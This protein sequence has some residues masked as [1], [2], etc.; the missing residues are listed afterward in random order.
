MIIQLQ[1]RPLGILVNGIACKVINGSSIQRSNCY[2]LDTI[3]RSLCLKEN[4][5]G[6]FATH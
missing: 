4:A 6:G 1:R 2:R 5:D 3:S